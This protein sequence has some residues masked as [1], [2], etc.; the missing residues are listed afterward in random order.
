MS[1]KLYQVSCKFPEE[2]FFFTVY[3]DGSIYIDYDK[4]PIALKNKHGT[5]PEDIAKFCLANIMFE[6]LYVGEFK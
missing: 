5:T 3:D 4:E 6:N 1:A 2:N